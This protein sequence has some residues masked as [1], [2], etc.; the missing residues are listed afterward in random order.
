MVSVILSLPK[1][2]IFVVLGDPSN[3]GETGA[4]IGKVIAVGVL[5]IVT[6]YGTR[7]IRGRLAIATREIKAEREADIAKHQHFGAGSS[8]GVNGQ[9][10]MPAAATAGAG[11]ATGLGRDAS[12]PTAIQEDEQMSASERREW[13]QHMEMQA[14]ANQPQNA[15]SPY[16]SNPYQAR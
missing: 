13:Q 15:G 16:D 2:I 5:V 10:Q 8:P 12:L 11:P 1:Q 9:Q 3:K 14:H 4:K 6:L 7:W